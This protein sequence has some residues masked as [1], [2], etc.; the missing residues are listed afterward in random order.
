MK[1]EVIWLKT[2]KLR[3][4]LNEVSG[5][6]GDLGTFVPLIVG[7]VLMGSASI[8]GALFWAG[9]FFITT[10]FTF[11]IPLAIQPMKAISTLAISNSYSQEI[12]TASG[13][14]AGLLILFAYKFKILT[15]L[16]KRLSLTI[17][18]SIQVGLGIKLLLQS[19]KMLLS[20]LSLDFDGVI[21]GIFSIALI[22]LAYRIK[23]IPSA[24]ILVLIGTIISIAKNPSTL[25]YLKPNLE[26]PSFIIPSAVD[27]IKGVELAI[28]Q[29]PLTIAN[30]LLASVALIEK[31]FPKVHVKINSVARNV[32]YMN[33][34]APLLGGIPMCHGAG[35]IAAWYRFGARKGISMII[36]GSLLLFF[37]LFYNKLFLSIIQTFPLGILGAMLLFVSLQLISQVK[38]LSY[39][40]DLIVSIIT[41]IAIAVKGMLIGLVVGA[42]LLY[43]LKLVLAKESKR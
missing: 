39:R 7:M 13:I 26:L 21:I 4:Y 24:L 22:L 16:Q 40:Y 25:L 14:L 35:G 19:L 20:K 27:F 17:I 18:V 23:L 34:I 15:F 9:F 5:S 11:G 29:V 3:F 43:L 32:A 10:G 42:V 37:G 41:G 33:L 6:F 36:F 8:S 28:A 2:S 31:L 12:V 38:S 30:S 1:Q